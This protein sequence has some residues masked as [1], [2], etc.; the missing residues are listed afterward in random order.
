MSGNP[1]N[2]H[3]DRGINRSDHPSRIEEKLAALPTNPGVYQ[4]KDVTGRVLYVG[5]AQNLRN[6]VRQ[7]FQKSRN[8]DPR[9]DAMVSK[10]QDLDIIVT[11]SE[12]EAL[13]LEAN[14]IKKL[15]PRY[16]VVLKDDKSYPFI[17]ITNEPFPR[18]FVTRRVVRDGSKYFGPFTDVKT[19][20][21]ALKTVRDIF[22]IRSCNYDLTAES[23]AKK[24]F[25]VCLDYHIKKCE[26]PCEGLVSQER[27]AMM[28]DQVAKVLRGKTHAVVEALEQEMQWLSD[29]L[30]FEEAALVRKRIRALQVY[31]ERQKVVDAKGVDRDIA[32]IAQKGEDACGVIFKVREGK[33]LGS[34]HFYLSNAIGKSESELLEVLLERYY[35]DEEDV[36]PELLLSAELEQAD[37]LRSW[38]K[39]QRNVDVRFETPKAGDKAKLVAMARNN[40][41]FLLDELEIQRLKRGEFIP[42][43]VKALQRDLRLD[44]PPRRIECFDISNLQG[45]DTVASM[46]VF[47]EGK[48]K[49]SEYRKFKIRTVSG[50]DDFASMQEVIERRYSKLLEGENPLPDLIMVDG[51]KGQLSSAVEV[52]Q[53]LGIG[54]TPIIGLA[55]R[56]EEV[57]VPQ[58]SE[59]VSIPR[60][61]SG[62]RLLQQIRNEAHRFAI[63]YHRTLRSKR[64]LQTELDLIQGIGKKRATELLEAFGSVQGVKFATEEQLAE[65]VGQKTAE[66]IKEYFSGEG[67]SHTD[68]SVDSG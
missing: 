15:K 61:S 20:R 36:P 1:T 23:I 13:I 16:N 25:K 29:G 51:G 22:M 34:R 6:R 28:I 48:P 32:A 30:R 68:E 24:K 2:S 59:P 47:V 10:V 14:L 42:H 43:S 67:V 27:Y 49:K 60:T 64:T 19:M 50:P 12:V 65:I 31:T 11:D 9:I 39:S 26:G 58:Q 40:A 21:F 37:L 5:K 62:L 52:L 44:A 35:L 38:L 8:T 63:T 46:V 66:K 33:V 53:K 55:K 7:Y 57:F 56:L 54:Q 17:R 41:M 18:V 3:Q 4:F 45:S